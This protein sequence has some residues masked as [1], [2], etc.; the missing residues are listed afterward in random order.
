MNGFFNVLKTSGMTSSKVVSK[1]K[2][3]LINVMGEPKNVSVGHMGTLDPGG[4]GVLPIAVGRAT[5]LFDYMLQKTKV[6]RA[7]FTFGAETDT[8]DSYGKVTE[9]TDRI[10]DIS[11]VERIIPSLV[12]DVDQIPPI[13]SAKSIGGVKAYDLARRGLNPE[14]KPKRVHIY[15]I[16]LVEQTA[17]D[18]FVFDIECSGGT[19]VRSIARDMAYGLGTV[20]YMAYIIRT[21]SG[22]FTIDRSVTLDELALDPYRYITAMDAVVDYPTFE[23]SEIGMTRMTNGLSIRSNVEDGLYAVYRDGAIY[24]IAESIDGSISFKTRLV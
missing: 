24:G 23:P 5:R 20:G 16:E 22:S 18:T 4:A 17:P 10:P 9:L 21:R 19:Y 7:A 13:Y 15:S 6:Y 11:E 8:L 12:G 14:L 2:H 3:I 1:V